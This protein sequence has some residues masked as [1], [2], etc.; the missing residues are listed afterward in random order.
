MSV[1][2]GQLRQAIADTITAGVATTPALY[3]YGSVVESIMLPAVVIEPFSAD[4]NVT[5]GR[6]LDTFDF[7]L[8]VLVSRADPTSAQATLD[9]LISGVG[10]SSIRRALYD[11]PDLGLGPSVDTVVHSMKG[12]GGS[13]EGYGISHIGAILQVCVSV[14]NN[15]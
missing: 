1:T 15:S 4:F 8:F 10:D 12:Y 2:M 14:S 13:M 9:A 5:F 3:T 7:N 6:G 11:K